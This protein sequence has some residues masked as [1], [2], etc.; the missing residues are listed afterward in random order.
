M[1]QYTKDQNAIFKSMFGTDI[2]GYK[3]EITKADSIKAGLLPRAKALTELS[4]EEKYKGSIYDKLG[5][6]EQITRPESTIV[7]PKMFPASQFPAP[8]KPL[9]E[10][11]KIETERKILEDKKKISML[12]SEMMRDYGIG[13]KEYDTIEH[14]AKSQVLAN[15][16]DYTTEEEI[17]NNIFTLREVRILTRNLV[18]DY[19]GGTPIEELGLPPRRSIT[20]EEPMSDW[21]NK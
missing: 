1:P 2:P 19:R 11:Q 7:F 3:P 20:P 12:K 15:R 18:K 9:T 6:R 13:K 4:P 21:L 10:A 17:M 16:P 5:R 14:I 8:E